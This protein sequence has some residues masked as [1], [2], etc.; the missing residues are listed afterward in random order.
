MFPP[1]AT[2]GD[3]RLAASL[4]FSAFRITETCS[5]LAFLSTSAYTFSFSLEGA[6]RINS[7]NLVDFK[8]LGTLV[9]FICLRPHLTSARESLHRNF[10]RYNDQWCLYRLRTL[11]GS[12][13]YFLEEDPL[14]SPLKIFP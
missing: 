11:D 14:V 5:S 7:E 1:H 10:H 13:P 8:V 4:S 6:L 2:T 9:I 12:Y 3:C